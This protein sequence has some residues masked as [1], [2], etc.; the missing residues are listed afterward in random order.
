MLDFGDFREL[1]DALPITLKGLWPSD[2]SAPVG[3]L[4]LVHKHRLIVCKIIYNVFIRMAVLIKSSRREYAPRLW[5][6]LSRGKL[7]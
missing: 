4:K 2:V 7:P 1:G 6:G 3:P 5:P